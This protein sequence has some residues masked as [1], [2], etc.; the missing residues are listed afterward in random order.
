MLLPT[1]RLYVDVAGSWVSLCGRQ[2]LHHSCTPRAHTAAG[3]HRSA[4]QD[5]Q[6]SRRHTTAGAPALLRQRATCLPAGHQGAASCA[7]A[8]WAAWRCTASMPLPLP[9]SSP[10]PRN[11]A[12]QGLL[13]HHCCSTPA[14]LH[15]PQ[16]VLQYIRHPLPSLHAHFTLLLLC[17]AAALIMLHAWLR[18]TMQPP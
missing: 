13:N 10:L 14:D 1:S 15:H 2:A 11:T 5:R 3:T 9:P 18:I 8:E 12:T 17:T 4:E 6:S 16:Q 7:Y